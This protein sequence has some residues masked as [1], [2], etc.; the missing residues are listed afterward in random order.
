MYILAVE[1]SCDDTSASVIKVIDKKIDKLKVLSNVIAPQPI[2]K[3]FGGVVPEIAA[4]K[5]AVNVIPTIESALKK[6][7]LALGDVDVFAVTIGPGLVTSLI[8]G[9]ETVKTLAYTY[10]KPIIGVNHIEG[11]I[12]ANFIDPKEE[13]VFPSV[14]L[15]VS[16]GHTTLVL[17][18]KHGK[19]EIIGNTR[20]DAA[21]E[22]Y[23][24]GAKMLGL[25]YPGGPEISKYAEKFENNP[26]VSE[27]DVKIN[28]PRPM[29]GSG[30]YDFSFSG[31]KTAL[32]YSLRKDKNWKNRVPE[33]AFEYQQ[34]IN[35]VLVK[36]TIKAAKEYKVK[37]IMLSGGV[38]AN[39]ALREQF[40]VKISKE[41]DKISFNVP[42]LQFTTDNAGM[43]ATTAYYKIK[44]RKFTNWKKLKLNVKIKL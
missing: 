15:T 4:R 11:H 3:Q 13:I 12:Y 16:G 1:S 14:I 17:M 41:F 2:H 24:K 33:Y 21:G 34:A 35:D 25:S 43:I 5:H 23:D 9:I 27:K 6:A 42:E 7:N 26:N 38:S 22:A 10:N 8:S 36:K 32:L 39:S 30:D 29:L 20:D 37:G 40:R 19:Y 18:K 44:K 28:L 31:L